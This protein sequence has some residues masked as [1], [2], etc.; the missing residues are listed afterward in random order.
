MCVT[1]CNSVYQCVSKG[2]GV[3]H[4][5]AKVRLKAKHIK[6]F[7]V[8]LINVTS[9]AIS[10]FNHFKNAPKD[11]AKL[12]REAANLLPLLTEFEISS[13]S[14]GSMVYWPTVTWKGKGDPLEFKS[15][16]KM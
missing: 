7:L 6:N 10:C 16:W 1:V 8:Q 3:S 5:L 4:P 15:A 11:R 12:A 9:K 2:K 14:D 13:G